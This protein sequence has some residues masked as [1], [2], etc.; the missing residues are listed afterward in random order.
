MKYRI[1]DALKNISENNA[2][3]VELINILSKEINLPAHELNNRSS[4]L[5]SEILHNYSD[6]A[7]STID[8]FTHKIVKTFAYDLKLPVN[9]NIETN[10][11]D[12]YQK[13]ISGLIAKVGE[14]P[15]LTELLVKYATSNAEDNNGWDPE[16]K[17]AEFSNLMQKEDAEINLDKLK[18]LN[19]QELQAFQEEIN[20]FIKSFKAIV[21]EAGAKAVRLIEENN[22]TDNNFWYTKAGPHRV[23]YKWK[24]ISNEKYSDLLSKRVLEA[25]T[26]DKWQNST[27]TAEENQRIV[28]I[29]PKLNKIA[30]E[31]L[32]YITENG[33]HYNLFSL[34][35]KNIYS[36]IL[37]NELKLISEE[38]KT[39]EQI[40]FISEF[41]SKISN[42]VSEEPAP[43]IY[44]RLG[45]RYQHYLLDEFQDTSTLQWMNLL[46]LIDNSL[47][48]GKFNLIVGDGKQSIYRWRNANVQQFN[49]L[50][51]LQNPQNNSV[52]EERKDSLQ[53]N[54]ALEILKTNYRSLKE[55][56]N[57][58]NSFFNYLPD[59]ILSAQF[60]SIYDKQA[61]EI[62]KSK[63]GYVT[64]QY[65]KVEK[66]ILD[67]RTFSN[68]TRHITNAIDSG[69][70]YKDICVIVR[71]NSSGNKIANHLI[72]QKIPV[73]SSDSLLLKNNSEINCIVNF[74]KHLNNPSD[75]ISAAS[76]LN[77]CFIN[78]ESSQRIYDVLNQ[79][80]S[81]IL[82][83]N[84]LGLTVSAELF[85]QKNVFDICVHIISLLKLESKNPQYIRFFLDEVND[86]LVNK[87]GSVNDFI[88]WWGKRQDQA[89]LI[90]PEGVNAVKIMT[91]HKSKGLE[92]PVVILPFF[93]WET[94]KSTNA[95][96]EL[97]K[98]KTQ[99]PIG[100][101]NISKGISDAGLEE[102]YELEK[103]EQFLDNLNLIYVAF[104][105]AVE[106]LHVIS[107]KS[108]AYRK[109]TISDWIE[110]YIINNINNPSE[111][112]IELGKPELKQSQS[113]SESLKS[114]DIS[115][116]NINNNPD[117]IKI[118]GTHKLKTSE[119]SGMAI[120]NGIKMHYI[121]SE[122]GSSADIDH[123][124]NKMT[125][126][127]I[128]SSSEKENLITKINSFVYHPLIS[129]YYS[130]NY[131]FKNEA[132]LITDTGELLRPDKVIYDDDEVVIIDYKTGQP[133]L[134]KHSLQ[135]KK[136][137]DALLNMGASKTKSI[138]VYLDENKVEII[139]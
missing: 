86:Y 29:V 69:F 124:L 104:T 81:L 4:A 42:I 36:I 139:N 66:E 75:L 138:L 102:V 73:I 85:Y 136:Y 110:N 15:E 107:Y 54:F 7:I 5:L 100:V 57:F 43:F 114:F 109:E 50:P 30:T 89:S 58:N 31:T 2:K 61:Q 56:V 63:G 93:N 17:L 128:I 34:I 82:A 135:M 99:L 39:E 65:G 101:I 94:Y 47:G 8:S 95:W 70:E 118:K 90:I 19:Q 98:F 123:V 37:V 87:T 28:T 67:E 33:K 122:I 3:G 40:V 106:R 12:F 91:I 18:K 79:T 20:E 13:V 9:F 120:E 35:E 111:E 14:N 74:L 38:F 16:S 46:P 53:R 108:K 45:E 11:G 129:K 25:I 1:L 71:N 112:L 22:L 77:Y 121:L 55:V 133:D 76:V 105:R 137:S 44:E 130:G 68:L 59:K 72:E 84:K 51:D 125:D 117:L 115:E 27:N 78:T 52:I 62:K 132:E 113:H 119:E 116:L 26:K 23:F 92:F 88:I 127:G 32:D 64:L 60:A 10:T 131:K 96:V 24:S 80:K 83:L 41:N 48:M 103:N 126:T 97:E 6:F 134:R 21:K 49:I